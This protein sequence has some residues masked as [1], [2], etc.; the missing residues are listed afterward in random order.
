MHQNFEDKAGDFP[1]PVMPVDTRNINSIFLP[2]NMSYLED[3]FV[4]F[5]TGSKYECG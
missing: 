4:N 1:T 3:D 2:S 5:S